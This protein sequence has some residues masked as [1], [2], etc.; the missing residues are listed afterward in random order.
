M[1]TFFTNYQNYVPLRGVFDPENEQD[2]GFGASLGGAFGAKGRQ[3][4][5]ALG[6]YAYAT[7]ILATTINQNQNSVVRSEKN[8]VGQSF[9][10]LLRA[11]TEKTGVYA[12]I[13]DRVPTQRRTVLSDGKP[14]TRDMPDFNAAQDPMIMVVKENGSDV[15]V[16]FEDEKIAK[17]M[18]GNS[19][20]GSASMNII[21]RGMLKIN[22]YLSNINTS[23]NPEFVVSN[24]LRDLQTAG[25]NV[26]QYDEKGMTKAILKGI[27]P[28]LGGIEKSIRTTPIFAKSKTDPESNLEWSKIY[29]DFVD[30]GGKNATN[31]MDTIADQMNS[32]KGILGDISEAGEKGKFGVVKQKFLGKGKSLLQFMEDYNTIVENGV[33]VATYKALI[34]R[35]YSRERAAQAAGS[36]TVNFS[37]GGEYRSLMN[38]WY[39]FLMRTH[40]ETESAPVKIQLA[41]NQ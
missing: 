3:D 9:L 32:L 12:K 18:K 20:L 11:D 25:V 40:D 29:E 13:L 37:K 35:G 24:F 27:K 15:Y 10:K 1:R 14:V 22:R 38:A 7:D 19:G 4:P 31:Q 36:V 2:I 5:K 23:Y 28:A 30:A 33:R 34:D 21:N 16:R 17:A 39:L 41:E 6:R 8:L 26:Q